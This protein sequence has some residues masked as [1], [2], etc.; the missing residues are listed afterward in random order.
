MVH[1]SIKRYKRTIFK[2]EAEMKKMKKVMS[3]ALA[4]VIGLA[5]FG[6]TGCGQ[7]DPVDVSIMALK[8]PTAMGMV[9]FMD[10]V[11]SGAVTDNNYEFSIAAS[12]DEVTPALTKGEVDIAALPANMA[13]ILYNNTDGNV[14]VLAVNTLG[15]IYI[16]ETGDTVNSVAD[17]KGKT[18]YA[19]GK[20]ATPEYSLNYILEKNGLT[21]GEDVQVEWK[22]EHSECV[23]ALANDENGIAMLPQPFVT[24][25]QTQNPNIRVA[26]DLT[27]EWDKLQEGEDPQST[28]ITGVIVANK[29]FVENNPEAVEA[30]LSHYEESVNY[31]NDNTDDAAKLVGKYDIV[32]EKVAQKALPECNIVYIAGD[33]MKEKLSGYLS[34]LME[35]N[36]K[37]IGGKLPAD[38]F[39]YGQ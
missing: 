11:D 14:Q 26:L 24:T 36:P 23:A 4:A 21:I 25:A 34:V 33:E 7:A 32:P 1:E 15:V 35:Q 12:A 19:S 27:E 5:G 28:M 38:D 9:K 6:L 22:S 30:F 29:D 31:V 2:G 17:L 3:L 37:A 13:S 18:I 16:C 20:G 8:G 39:Y 10:D